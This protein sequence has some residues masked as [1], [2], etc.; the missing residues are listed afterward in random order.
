[1]S[2]KTLMIDATPILRLYARWRSAQLA[3]QDP[4]REQQRQLVRLLRRAEATRF[5][6]DHRF[7]E[8][9]DIADFQARVPLRRY[10]DMWELYWRRDFPRLTDCSWPGTIPFFALTSGTTS[11]TTKYI[12]CSREMNRANDR[13]AAD[14]LVHHLA[15]RP[16]SRVLG[17]KTLMLGGSTDLVET[18][19]GIRSGDL[20]GIA[21]SEMPGWARPYCFPPAKLALIA[22]W[23]EKIEKLALAALGKDIRAITGTPSWLLI[24]FER[25]FSRAGG[26]ASELRRVFPN[27]ELL[28]HG[29]VNFAPYRR[30]FEELL[31]G[32]HAELREVYPASEGFIAIADRGFGEGLRLI[33]DNGLFYEFVPARELAGRQ[34]TRHWLG[35]AQPGLDYALVVSSCAGL[36]AYILGDTVKLTQLDPPRLLVTGRIAYWLSAFGEHLTGDE[37][38]QAVSRAAEAAQARVADFAVGPVFPGASQARGGHLYIVEFNAAAPADIKAFAQAID[39]QLCRI[40]D[41]YRAHRAR[42]F[43]LEPPAVTV[44]EHGTFAAWMRSR[45]QLG[46]QHKVPRIIGDAGLFAELR[47]FATGP[48]GT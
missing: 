15:N 36:W 11:G 48:R 23:E 47:A 39:E 9:R 30:Q 37:I 35:T 31:G 28:I 6:R 2:A 16:Q 29:G 24:F 40:N 18:A 22:D 1:V 4:L 46:G 34:P 45:G 32:S 7:A 20:S 33:V 38:E 17:G 41:D 27:L 12:P 5:G 42:G 43:G 13:A 14:I 10:E 19:P 8:I 26:G 3:R 25:V 21:V 44:V